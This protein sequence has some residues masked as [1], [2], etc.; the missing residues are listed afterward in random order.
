MSKV[1]DQSSETDV[2]KYVQ[3]FGAKREKVLEQ[4]HRRIVGQEDVLDQ[5]LT[6]FFVGG[7]SVLKSVPGLAKTLMVRTLS[8]TLSL[9]FQRIQFTPDLMPSDITGSR[10][11]EEDRESGSRSFRFR[12]GPIFTNILLADEINR[13]PPK[14]QAALLEA[15]E[16]KQVS[17]GRDVYSLPDPFV[18]LATQNP[19]EQEGTYTLPEAQ[20]DRFFFMIKLDYS[21]EKEEQEILTSTTRGQ[22]PDLDPVLDKEEI[23]TAQS[24][25]RKIPVSDHVAAYATRL[26]RATRP[27]DGSSPDFVEN[28]VN[29]GCSPRAGQALLLAGKANALLHGRTDV[30]CD[31]IR[32]Y[33]HP[34]LRHRILLN[35]SATSE[36]MDTDDIISELLNQVPEAPK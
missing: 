5:L 27:D 30:A 3:A 11:L 8:R 17:S 15:M 36:G 29:L 13:T 24:L 35:F 19:I 25:V 12:K 26:M 10:I 6:A 23:R 31:D 22:E 32:K 1:K 14:T 7:H 4:V 2:L 9:D 16:E 33:A 28:Y 34:I 21:S 20:L 18:V